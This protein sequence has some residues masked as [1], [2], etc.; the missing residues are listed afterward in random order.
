MGINENEHASRAHIREGVVLHI[1]KS[2]TL[3]MNAC[4]STSKCAFRAVYS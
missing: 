2:A 4:T 3:Y 1:L